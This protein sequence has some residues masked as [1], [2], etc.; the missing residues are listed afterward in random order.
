MTPPQLAEGNVDHSITTIVRR[1]WSSFLVPVGALLFYLALLL[2]G[3]SGKTDGGFL[4]SIMNAC[5]LLAA[6]LAA[7]SH[8]ERISEKLGQ[9]YGT[10]VLT[11]SVTTIEVALIMSIML[12]EK[13][14]STLARDTIFSVI[15]IVC[16]G[17]VGVCI[18]AGALRFH[19]QEFEVKGASSYLAVLSALSVLTLVLPSYTRSTAIP[20][21]TEG[22]LGFVSVV[23]LALYGLFLY[24]QT[25]RHTEFFTE[26]GEGVLE[27]GIT[28]PKR[29]RSFIVAI[30]LLLMSL[31]AVVL[32]SKTFTASVQA[33]LTAAGAPLEAVGVIVAALIL[34]PEAIAA[35][36][37]ALQNELQRSLNLSLGSSLATIGLTIPAVGVI[38]L[39]LE[40]ELVLGLQPAQIVLLALTLLLSA[41]TFGTGRTNILYGF[42]HLIVFATYVFL[43]F[44]P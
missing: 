2:G 15:M 16:N 26:A 8:A 4:L 33:G 30:I 32:L 1:H 41:F 36:R 3:V 40:R 31:A 24:I 7:V 14:S 6:V 35:L 29:K 38:S 28:L 18:L 21:L 42:V 27:G 39:W 43:I 5:V 22:Q 20:V 25:I 10:L 34:L 44:I 12:G 9:P 37:A 23:T 19:E 13:A 11:I 17:L